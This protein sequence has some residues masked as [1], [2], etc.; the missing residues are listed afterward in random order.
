ME[1]APGHHDAEVRLTVDAAIE[2][3]NLLHDEPHGTADVRSVLVR[4]GF[5]RAP[6]A[7]AAAVRRLEDRL[8]ERLDQL[9]SLPD[10]DVDR[11]ARWVNEALRSIPVEPWLVEHDG[12]PLHIHWTR[13]NASFD[14]QVVGDILMALAQ[15]LVDHGT[16]RFGRCGADDCDH[17]FYDTTRNHSRRFCTDQRCA[18]RTHTATHRARRRTR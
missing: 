3:A 11:A 17:L 10:T 5:T 13:S 9:R 18:S 4:Q 15:E 2:L 7:P 14:D 12:A 16:T 6:S 8:R 1:V